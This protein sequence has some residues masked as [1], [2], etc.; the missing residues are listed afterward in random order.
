MMSTNELRIATA[1]PGKLRL[2][3]L[4]GHSSETDHAM[5]VSLCPQYG[6]PGG[7]YA[8]HSEPQQLVPEQTYHQQHLQ[9]QQQQA[10]VCPA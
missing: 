10:V 5:N 2:A 4:P 8:A 6:A 3:S 1:L 7:Q 9:Q